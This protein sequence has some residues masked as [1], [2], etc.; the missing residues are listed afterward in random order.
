MGVYNSPLSMIFHLRM[1]FSMV[2]TFLSRLLLSHCFLNCC[3]CGSLSWSFDNFSSFMGSE[4]S[5][6]TWTGLVCW[7]FML[8]I[9]HSITSYITWVVTGGISLKGKYPNSFSSSSG[10]SL[11]FSSICMSLDRVFAKVFGIPGMYSNVMFC[12]SSSTAQLF[13][14]EF[15]VFFSKNFFYGRWSL[16]TVILAV[17]M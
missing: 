14:F 16:F 8:P 6:F 2:Y 13:T 3:M 7:M 10:G 9:S 11:M 5:V 12:D 1:L 15:R 4:M 17:S